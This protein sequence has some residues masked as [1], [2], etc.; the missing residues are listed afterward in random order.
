MSNR[1]NTPSTSVGDSV[2]I[3]H[4]KHNALHLK[5]D[6]EATAAY[7]NLSAVDPGNGSVWLVTADVPFYMRI[8]RDEDG[9]YTAAIAA[10]GDRVLA[11]AAGNWY[12]VSVD[13]S[14]VTDGDDILLEFIQWGAV[15]G[16]IT[17]L[18]V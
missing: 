6:I 5:G 11:C 16:K 17:A 9:V 4:L 13:G 8:V 18:M 12:F 7:V 15:T 1:I 2:P 14:N 10:G 3:V